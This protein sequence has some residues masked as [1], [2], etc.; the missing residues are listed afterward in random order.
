MKTGYL[1]VESTKWIWNKPSTYLSFAI[2]I[3][4]F[5]SCWKWKYAKWNHS[6][7]IYI[8]SDEEDYF[9]TDVEVYH[10]GHVVESM[11]FDLWIDR[12]P[13]KVM[14]VPTESKYSESELKQRIKSK[15]GTKYDVLSLIFFQVIYRLKFKLVW[16]G[17]KGEKA[18]NKLYYS[19]YFA[20]VHQLPGWYKMST[21]DILIYL[22]KQ[23]KQKQS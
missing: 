23:N 16:L 19:E 13:G 18:S 2:K 17:V 11:D 22:D 7:I 12:R 5:L 14:I 9:W 10:T 1:I 20:W 15:L 4:Q 6:G 3:F 8:L 21:S